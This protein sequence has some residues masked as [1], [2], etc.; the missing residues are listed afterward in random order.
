[1]LNYNFGDVGSCCCCVNNEIKHNI[2]YCIQQQ[3]NLSSLPF[4]R[5]NTIFISIMIIYN[6]K[7]DQNLHKVHG[8]TYF[9]C[10]QDSDGAY[11][12]HILSGTIQRD[13]PT[14][15][16]ADTQVRDTGTRGSVRRG[17]G[18][19]ADNLAVLGHLGSFLVRMPDRMSLFQ[20]KLVSGGTGYSHIST[21]II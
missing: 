7:T 19:R 15:G 18:G 2:I 21:Y 17:P 1:M 12:W 6:C 16:E 14:V 20:L 11:Y 8:V 9:P 10:A 4:Q 13:P 3:S 5:N